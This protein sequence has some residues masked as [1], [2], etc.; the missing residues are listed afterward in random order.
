LCV[1]V[2]LGQLVGG[3]FEPLKRGDVVLQLLSAADTDQSRGHAGSRKVQASAKLRQR[4]AAADRDFIE[5][6]HSLEVL[7]GQELPGEVRA[8]TRAICAR[9]TLPWRRRTSITR[10]RLRS[11]ASAG[12]LRNRLSSAWGERSMLRAA[13]QGFEHSD[14]ESEVGPTSER[15]HERVPWE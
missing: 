13:C 4:L 1:T 15:S 2:D 7:L 10:R 3:E 6:A 8:V 5:R 11:P 12:S 9:L 14:T